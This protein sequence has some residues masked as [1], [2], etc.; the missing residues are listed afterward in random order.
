[1]LTRL[2]LIGCKT[3]VTEGTAIA[4]AETDF[5][6]AF[7]IDVKPLPELI[8]QPYHSTSL[9]P[10][11]KL[12]GKK[13]YE[14][15][16]KT[17]VKGSGAAGTAPPVGPLIQALGHTETPVTS[18][19]VT[20]AP[21][22]QPPSA[23]FKSQGKSC[24]IKVYEDGTLHVLAGARGT[25][26]LIAVAGQPAVN[27]WTFSGLYT[28][29]TDAA[30][31]TNTPNATAPPIVQSSSLSLQGYAAVAAKLEIDWGN[32]LQDAD[33][34]S[35]AN[36]ILVF[37]ITDRQPV[38]SC[39]P[40]AVLVATHD[41]YGKMMSGATASSSIVIGSA[42]G[43]ICTITLPKTQYGE[44]SP[45]DRKGIMTFQIPLIFSRNAGDDW[46]SEV[47]T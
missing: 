3:E 46:I 12:V 38:G 2:K 36:G 19:S 40:E 21:A 10:Y 31:P 22:S 17:F 20:Y 25:R 30:F 14:L 24:T 18:T 44:I 43:N 28:A 16:F 37:R 7:D 6:H 5:F 26:K 8:D 15:K 13:K 45:G 27:E 47:Y 11:A 34:V 42:A 41:F 33:N 35:S 9:D 29:V 32:V 39:D 4:L 23:N 1:M